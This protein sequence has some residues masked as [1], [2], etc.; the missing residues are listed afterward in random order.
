MES[1]EEW[2]GKLVEARRLIKLQMENSRSDHD[3]I[4]IGILDE[5]IGDIENQ[6]LE[7]W[8]MDRQIN[9]EKDSGL[10]PPF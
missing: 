4:V 9:I 2:I 1:R 8:N 6:L 10:W 7:E 5:V 3:K